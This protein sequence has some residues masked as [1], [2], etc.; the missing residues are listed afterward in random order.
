MKHSLKV[1]LL[2]F[3]VVLTACAASAPPAVGVWDISMDTPLGQ[4]SAVLTIADDGTG[5][6]AGDQGE[7]ALNGIELDGNAISFSTDIDA[8]GQSFTLDF[9]GTVEGDSLNGEFGTPF[10]ALGVSGSRR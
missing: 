3:I 5:V 1:F 9:S 6:M 2:P 7:Q 8:Q 10:G 4:Q